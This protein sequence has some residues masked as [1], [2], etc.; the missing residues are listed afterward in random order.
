M[1]TNEIKSGQNLPGATHDGVDH[2][3]RVVDVDVESNDSVE[4]IVKDG[5]IDIQVDSPDGEHTTVV[6]HTDE[7]GHGE[8]GHGDHGHGQHPVECISVNEKPVEIHAFEATGL[9]IK[10]AAIRAHVAIELNFVLAE[11]RED[12]SSKIIGDADIVKL[13]EGMKFS[14]IR[15]DD[16]S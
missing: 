2:E 9:Q 5:E 4:V 16:N 8:H 14:A 7:H 6:I 10:Q 12:G 3:A 13:H 11:E 15:D 1:E